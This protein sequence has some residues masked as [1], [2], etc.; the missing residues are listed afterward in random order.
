[1]WVASK[2]IY[3]LD[4]F[5]KLFWKY[6]LLLKFSRKMI[7]KSYPLCYVAQ[8]KNISDKCFTLTSKIKTVGLELTFL[9]PL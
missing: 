6:H 8:T 4:A 2:H 5:V 9:Q 7:L 1:M 3:D